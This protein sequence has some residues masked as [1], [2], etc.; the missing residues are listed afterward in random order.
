M[1]TD[2]DSDTKVDVRTDLKAPS[3]YCVV[4]HNDDKTTFEFVVSSLVE[5]FSYTEDDAGDKAIE[6]DQDNKAVVAIMGYEIAEQ[7]ATE[8]VKWARTEGFPLQVTVE[9]A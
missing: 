4:Y 3:N 2:V 1:T 5:I 8:V 6:V 7:K 9:E